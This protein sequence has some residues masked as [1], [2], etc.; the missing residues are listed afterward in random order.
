MYLYVPFCT[1]TLQKYETLCE[2]SCKQ[3]RPRSAG[4]WRSQLIKIHTVFI[5]TYELVIINQNMKYRIVLTLNIN[6][7]LSKDK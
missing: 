5:A 4:F 6:L 2:L 1:F 3:C 7:Y